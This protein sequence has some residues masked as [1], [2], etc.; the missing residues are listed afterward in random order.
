MPFRDVIGHRRLLGLLARSVQRQ[1]LPPSLIF[2]GPAGVGKR[3]TATAVAQSLNCLAPQTIADGVDGCGMCSACRRT[4][5]GIHPDVLVIEPGDSGS[6][7]IDQVR[8]AVDR[9]GYRPFEGKRRV[10]IVD[11]ADALAAAA[12]NALLK[13]LEEP[14]ASS[15]FILVTSRPDVLLPTV[16]SRCLHLAFRALAAA[17]IAKALVARGHSDVDARAVAAAADGSLRRAL[18]AS[19]GELVEARE[20]AALVLTRAASA[21]GPQTRIEAAKGLLTKT[22]QDGASDREQLG[23]HLRA[24]GSLLRDVELLALDSD[25]EALANPDLR[26]TLDRLTKAYAGER[27]LH[28]FAAV[29]RARLA[30]ER[31]VGVKIVADWVAL[32]L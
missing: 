19:A 8:D 20:I 32:Q 9:T 4:A 29:D 31:N 25:S 15:V 1:S 7:K 26:P 10:V 3:L 6:I 16:R 18:Q 11:D 22:A 14:A 17:D 13:T 30:L 21:T 12:Q 5:R 27:G 28:A 24:I 23:A 2:A